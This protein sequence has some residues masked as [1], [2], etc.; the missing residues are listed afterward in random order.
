MNSSV[1]VA[2][3]SNAVMDLLDFKYSSKGLGGSRCRL[4]YATRVQSLHM[5]REFHNTSVASCNTV[6]TT[7]SIA[8]WGSCQHYFP[9]AGTCEHLDTEDK[10]LMRLLLLLAPSPVQ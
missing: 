6:L 7:S 2:S 10:S 5:S 4:E 3:W 8:S 9:H 1:E